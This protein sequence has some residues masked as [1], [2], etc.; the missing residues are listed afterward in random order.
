M[1]QEPGTD[2][3]IKTFCT[4]KYNVTFPMFSKISVKGNDKHPLY[5]FLTS[6]EKNGKI[7]AEVTWN[8]NKFIIDKNGKVVEHFNSKMKPNDEIF[9]KTIN[10]L[11]K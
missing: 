6:K 10:D 9:L 2:A 11:L 4:S 8:F 7:D 3:E 1:G 5:Q